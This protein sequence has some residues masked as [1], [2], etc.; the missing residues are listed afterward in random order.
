MLLA[1]SAAK[2]A[3]PHPGNGQS[4]SSPL[5]RL[6]C[7][8]KGVPPRRRNRPASSY[9][10]TC[11]RQPEAGHPRVNWPRQQ[12]ASRRRRSRD[13]DLRRLD[14]GDVG[15]G[16]QSCCACQVERKA[17]VRRYPRSRHKLI[18]LPA[19]NQSFGRRTTD[20]AASDSCTRPRMVSSAASSIASRAKA[21]EDSASGSARAGG[22]DFGGH[23]EHR[24]FGDLG[25]C[26]R[27][28]PRNVP[29]SIRNGLKRSE[30]QFG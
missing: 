25:W 22:S 4:V 13:P 28:W 2:L 17:P 7:H 15:L 16:G 10:T 29:F 21:G 30:S 20:R 23:A 12:A 5:R 18:R 14:P 3:S 8:R 24:V 6:Q 9:G 11:R 19:G 27:D 26:A 1:T